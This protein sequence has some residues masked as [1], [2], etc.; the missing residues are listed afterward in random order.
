M[1]NV[2]LWDGFAEFFCG[3]REVDEFKVEGL[4]I[5][6]NFTSALDTSQSM[7]LSGKSG[8]LRDGPH[9]LT[10]RDLAKI[11]CNQLQGDV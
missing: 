2:T 3:S 8:T 9:G 6:D 5:E 1:S 7:P 4:P 10:V 11:S